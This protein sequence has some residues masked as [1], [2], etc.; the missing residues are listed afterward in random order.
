M[1]RTHS[2]ALDSTEKQKNA[3]GKASGVPSTKDKQALVKAFAEYL[4]VQNSAP[5]R[6]QQRFYEK[7][8]TV[9]EMIESKYPE[10]DL[11][12]SETMRNL[13]N[14]ARNFL[15]QHPLRGMPGV[16]Y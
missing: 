15:K 3:L 14:A 4:S 16:S 1:I 13:E 7:W 12:S 11:Y 2:I 8:K 5:M 6:I 9:H 10:V